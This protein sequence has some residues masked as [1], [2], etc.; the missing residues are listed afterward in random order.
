MP[1][2]DF[3]CSDCKGVH[4]A[5]VGTIADPDAKNCP[6]CGSANIRK[7]ITGFAFH[8]EQQFADYSPGEKQMA[9]QNKK[10][11]ESNADKVRSGEWSLTSAKRVPHELRPQI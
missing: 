7:L 5:I 10:Y 9:L 2:F 8:P 6:A 4:E 11:I 1:V 3:E